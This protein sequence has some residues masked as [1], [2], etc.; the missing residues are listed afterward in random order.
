MR[1]RIKS[2]DSSIIS[3]LQTLEIIEWATLVVCLALLVH[4]VF[5]VCCD[6]IA[7]LFILCMNA[8]VLDIVLLCIDSYILF[9]CSPDE[10]RVPNPNT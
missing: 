1:V 8:L 9:S 3:I 7:F 2:T 5:H 6:N 10:P 4:V